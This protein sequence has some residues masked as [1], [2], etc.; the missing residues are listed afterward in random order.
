MF[1]MTSAF[2][3]LKAREGTFHARI[4]VFTAFLEN[5]SENAPVKSLNAVGLARLTSA[6]L[7][8]HSA[9]AVC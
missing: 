6:P 7:I 3:P 4:Q 1:N 9:D 5:E 2:V 8:S